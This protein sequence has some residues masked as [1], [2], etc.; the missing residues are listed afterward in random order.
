MQTITYR[1]LIPTDIPDTL[2]VDFTRYQETTYV[3]AL[4]D[5][6][7]IQK[8]DHFIDNWD[9]AKL[10]SVSAYLRGCAQRGGIVVGAFA[11][12]TCIGFTAIEP[13]RFGSHG[14]YVEL[15]YCHVTRENRGKGIGRQLFSRACQIARAQGIQK[16]Y[17]STHPA[18][19]SQGFYRAV[20]CVLAEEINPEI[21]A[22]E[23]LDLQLE[24][25]L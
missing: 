4:V 16:L 21:L 9:Q 25:T 17:L 8:E 15:S 12:E 5:G 13:D 19:E 3:L 1:Q 18:V 7:L 23:P 10:A 6:E 20:G 11:G 22:R 2:L 14:Q 24:L